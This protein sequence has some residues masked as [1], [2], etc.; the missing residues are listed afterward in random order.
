[1]SGPVNEKDEEC[2]EVPIPYQ[3]TISSDK[4]INLIGYESLIQLVSKNGDP[5]LNMCKTI[6]TLK[7]NLQRRNST[8]RRLNCEKKGLVKQIADLRVN[9]AE[10]SRRFEKACLNLHSVK[11]ELEVL[12]ANQSLCSNCLV[13]EFISTE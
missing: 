9:H 4:L 10:V 8:I 7:A 1:M 6:T 3:L 5:K 2:T 13:E 12:K 11:T